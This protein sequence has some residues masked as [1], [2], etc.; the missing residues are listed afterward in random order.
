[1]LCTKRKKN[2]ESFFQKVAKQRADARAKLIEALKPVLENY[3]KE[4]N[5]SII[6]N[7][8]DVLFAKTELN[9]TKP[10]ID[11]LN[12]KLPSLNLK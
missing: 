2:R 9:I 12:K 4:N 10:V 6:M 7:S 5:V 3:S 11:L 8:K 1:M